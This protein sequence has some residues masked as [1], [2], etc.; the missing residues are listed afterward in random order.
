MTSPQQSHNSISKCVYGLIHNIYKWTDLPSQNGE[1]R[2]LHRNWRSW[3]GHAT[4][5]VAAVAMGRW[6]GL[7]LSFLY[8]PLGTWVPLAFVAGVVLFYFWREYGVG[9]DYWKRRKGYDSKSDSVI[10]FW[11]VLPPVFILMQVPLVYAVLTA[12]TMITGIYLMSRF[13]DYDEPAH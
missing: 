11:V 6:A 13:I 7:H 3:F 9:G 2:L 8:L 4:V 1:T 5:S 12:L 10:D